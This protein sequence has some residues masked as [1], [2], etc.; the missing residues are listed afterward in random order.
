MADL[1]LCSIPDCGKSYYAK[2]C[3]NKHYK[4]LKKYGDPEGK[5]AR[6]P[7]ESTKFVTEVAL[8]YKGE[9][10]LIWPFARKSQGG[11]GLITAD[12]R[13]M[14]ASRYICILVNG[15]PSDPKLQAAHSCGNGHLGCVSPG[16]LRWATAKE[17]AA[18]KLS[19]PNKGK[20]YRHLISGAKNGRAKLTEDQARQA[21]SLKGV[22]SQTKI[23]AEFGVNKTTISYLHKRKSWAYL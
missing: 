12:G 14:H 9:E 15:H 2:G 23:A 16:H 6:G 21:L 20:D 22:I 18:D 10:C 3:C 13:M 17:N 5:A 7:C 1:R 4:R 8:P 19:G 11:Y